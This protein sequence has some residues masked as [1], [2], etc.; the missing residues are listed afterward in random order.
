MVAMKLWRR[1]RLR[2]AP[3]P[4]R[5]YMAKWQETL[6]AVKILLSTAVE[7]SSEEAAQQALTL[8][9]PVLANLQKVGRARVGG[10][11]AGGQ[12][13]QQHA[14]SSS[15]SICGVCTSTVLAVIVWCAWASQRP[16]L[17]PTAPHPAPPLQ[18]AGLMAAMRHPNIVGFLGVCAGEC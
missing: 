6:V 15:M 17:G 13:T 7:M 16:H 5:V 1:L 9:S 14:L 3:L 2:L 12:R 10:R 8:S 4:A 18:E 11:A